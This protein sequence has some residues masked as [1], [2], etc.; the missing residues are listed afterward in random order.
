MRFSAELPSTMRL[1]DLSQCEGSVLSP[2]PLLSGLN[3]GSESRR[4]QRGLG[5][6]VV[7]QCTDDSVQI[8][9]SGSLQRVLNPGVSNHLGANEGGRAAVQGPMCV[10]EV[11]AVS[12]LIVCGWPSG[13]VRHCL[14]W[15][16]PGA[17]VLLCLIRLCTVFPGV[18]SC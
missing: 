3:V 6:S 11:D 1:A 8:L 12:G 14:S 5:S 16:E 2:A 17:C 15:L 13:L 7:L 18:S 10:C 9:S 4:G